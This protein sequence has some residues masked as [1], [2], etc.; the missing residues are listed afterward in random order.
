MITTKKNKIKNYISIAGR[1]GYIIWGNDNLNGYTHKLYLV[2]Y[3]CDY[4]KTI[5]KTLKLLGDTIPKI[6]LEEADFN[7]I[8]MSDNCKILGIKNKGIAERILDLLR[9]EDGK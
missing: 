8:V 3:R 7:D 6:M 5:E 1:A 9:G 4:G 2:L